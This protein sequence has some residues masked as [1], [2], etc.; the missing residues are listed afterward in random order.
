MRKVSLEKV[1]K[2]KNWNCLAGSF[3]LDCS[4]ML[5]VN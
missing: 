5:N 1:Q 3:Q 2:A 4:L